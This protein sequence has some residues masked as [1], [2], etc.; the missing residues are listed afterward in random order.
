MGIVIGLA[1][2]SIAE[3]EADMCGKEGGILASIFPKEEKFS[4]AKD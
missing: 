1:V 3:A 2:T 4:F